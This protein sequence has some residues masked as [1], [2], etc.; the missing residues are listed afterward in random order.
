MRC[1]RLLLLL[2]PCLLAFQ[3]PVR[4]EDPPAP[5][6]APA[7]GEPPP[8][9]P[10]P[11]E[12]APE[13]PADPAAPEPAPAPGPATPEDEEEQERKDEEERKRLEA[14]R[15]QAEADDGVERPPL[16]EPPRPGPGG[17]RYVPGGA[18]LPFGTS[19]AEMAKVVEGLSQVARKPFLY[20]QPHTR[21]LD[22]YWI[23]AFEVTNAQYARFL[24]DYRTAYVCTGRHGT[25]REVAGFL[26]GLTSKEVEDD[27][28]VWRQVA[29]SN[30]DALVAALPD[31]PFPEGFRSAVLPRRDLTLV[32]VTKRPPDDWPGM[33]PDPERLAH[34]VRYVS[35]LDAVAFCEWAGKRLPT[36]FEWELAAR[37]PQPWPLPWG[38]KWKTDLSRC[39]WGARNA[40]KKTFEADTWV[41]GSAPGGRS[42]FDVY[43]MVGNVAEWTASRFEAY[44]PLAKDSPLADNEWLGAERIRVIRGGTAIDVA[45]QVLRPAYRNYIGEGVRAPPYAENRFKWVGFR[46]A[47][48]PKPGANQAPAVADRIYRGGR[49]KRAQP[50]VEGGAPA[51]PDQLE[52][53]RMS[54]SVAENH[55]PTDGDPENGV[56]VLGRCRA[57]VAIPRSYVLDTE[58]TGREAPNTTRAKG[59]AGL[60]RESETEGPVILLGAFH[61]DVQLQKV[62]K[63]VVLPPPANEEER[64]AREK[65]REKRRGKSEAPQ[66]VQGTLAPGSYILGLWHGRLCLLDPSREFQCFLSAPD[67]PATLDVKK[68]K[69]DEAPPACKVEVDVDLATITASYAVPLL[70]GKGADASLWVT[71]SFSVEAEAKDLEAPNGWR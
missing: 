64:K 27:R 2:L 66:V 46:P 54:G 53:E 1:H 13:P 45:L 71:C 6:P 14:E 34:P 22:P 56:C 20:E 10:A 9:E 70:H 19:P 51:R 35:Q 29:M 59:K 7:P 43:D 28:V 49:L 44:V 4:A 33:S 25:L 26:L 11:G 37:G 58:E 42:Q 52:M 61:A 21:S 3:A 47:W 57:V 32:F 17:M 60:L 36:E 41:V 18:D 68:L 67:K 24:E 65:E 31:V 55:I 38:M 8:A 12:P 30:K 23:D 15:K 16:P 69:P 48:W 63:R 5:A 50:G 39:N 40:N 62:W